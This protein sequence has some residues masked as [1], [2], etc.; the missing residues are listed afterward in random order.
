MAAKPTTQTTQARLS[1]IIKESRNTMRKD[2][3]LNGELDRLPQMAWLLF[4][5]AFDDLEEERE[6]TEGDYRPALE[7]EYRWRAWAGDSTLT[8]EP[9]LAFVNGKLLPRLR[10]LQGTGKAGDP[11][12]TL[13]RV[14]QDTQNRMLSGFLFRELVDQLDKVEFTNRD[15][16][17]TMAHLYESMLRE[18]RDAAG[19]SGEFYTP[20]PLVRF[21]VDRV[22][23]KPGE[24]VLDPAAGTGGFLVE[25]FAHMTEGDVTAEERGH[26]KAG[27]RGVE[28]KPMP[29]LLCQMNLLLHGIDQPDVV[30]QNSLGFSL[31]EMRRDGVDVV[32]T[33]PPFGGEEEKSVQANFPPHLQTAE[34]AWLFLQAVMA[35]IE[36]SKVGRAAVVVPNSTLFDRGVGGR[37]KAELMSKFNLHT[38]LR[39]PNGVFAPYTLIP[40]NV[41]FFERGKQQPH[42]WFYEQPMPEGRKQYTK[43]KPMRFEEFGECAEWWGGDTRNGRIATAHAWRVAADDIKAD[44]YNLDLRNP[45]RGDDLVHRSPVE[46]VDEL[47]SAERELL[48]LLEELQREV[49]GF[50]Q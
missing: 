9:L 38:V 26:A 1:S 41:L 24:T 30:E 12:D 17:H 8:G 29:F 19:D 45:D 2:A 21:I 48:G 16:I 40:S 4:L 11:R 23:P 36:R 50:A 35:R 10:K 5:K 13:R 7:L 33:N 46:L 20:R 34:T 47:V 28:K 6:L 14:F 3:G 39:L 31:A 32:I 44:G 37:I 15:D 42:V 43:T 49:K 22:D 25:A 18:M 27:I